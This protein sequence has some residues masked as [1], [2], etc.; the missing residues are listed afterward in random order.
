MA[1]WDAYE[2]ENHWID[3]ARYVSPKKPKPTFKKG[4]IVKLKSGTHPILVT[5]VKLS[6]LNYEYYLRVEYVSGVKQFSWRKQSDFEYHYDNLPFNATDKHINEDDKMTNTLYQF[7]DAND[8]VLFGTYLA[9]N[10]DGKW[11]ME[12][13]SSKNIILVDKKD[14]EE[15]LP[16][17][18]AVRFF[19]NLDKDYAYLAEKGKFDVGFY[20]FKNQ[21]GTNMVQVTALDTKSRAAT[22]EFK[23]LGKFN[24]DMY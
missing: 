14:A 1:D 3:A 9:T 17:T 10:S 18:I 20:L 22:V 24:V 8:N 23:P 5:D 11:V 12:D 16:Y 7:K 6:E 2:L 15:V 19:P 21:H 13:R 4:D